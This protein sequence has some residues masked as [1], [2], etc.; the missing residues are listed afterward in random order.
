MIVCKYI[1]IHLYMHNI[2]TDD[3]IYIHF[4]QLLYISILYST[5]YTLYTIY[6][7]I[8]TYAYTYILEYICICIHVLYKLAL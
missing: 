3:C 1:Y 4:I 7:R 2:Y 6:K 5:Y 8:Y